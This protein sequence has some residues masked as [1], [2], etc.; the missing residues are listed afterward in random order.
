MPNKIIKDGA[1]IDDQWQLLA[2]DATE[3]PAGAV[4]IPLAL[5]NTHKDQL[6]GRE[7][8]GIWLDSDESP[9]L[10]ASSLEQFQLIAINF[11]AFADGRGFSYG[12][13]L[14]ETHHYCGELRAIGGIIRDQL[15]FLKRCGFNSFA[16]SNTD[17]DAALSS[18]TDFSNSYQAAID[19]PEPL[20]R[21][22]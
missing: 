1:V 6:A 15:Y 5:W 13:E 20:F 2:A 10:I 14:R 17:L 16:V 18:F 21:R 11:P 22:R 9:K 8:L 12:R 19:Q 3:I 7:Q 4:I